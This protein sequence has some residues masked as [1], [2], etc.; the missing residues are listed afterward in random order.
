MSVL[1]FMIGF[2]LWVFFLSV[3]ARILYHFFR[4]HFTKECEDHDKTVDVSQRKGTGNLAPS[5]SGFRFE[6]LQTGM[7][8]RWILATRSSVRLAQGNALDSDGECG[9]LEQEKIEY[10]EFL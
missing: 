8:S 5:S 3:L 2:I 9:I 1:S 7:I 4:F 10:S 6:H